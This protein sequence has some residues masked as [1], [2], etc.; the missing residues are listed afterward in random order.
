MHRPTILLL[1]LSSSLSTECGDAL[2]TCGYRVASVSTR[3]EFDRLIA[4]TAPTLAIVDDADSVAAL[5]I[6]DVIGL[7]AIVLTT[8]ESEARAV[9]ALRLGALDYFRWPGERAAFLARVKQLVPA[10]DDSAAV[11]ALVGR[12]TAIRHVQQQ[13]EKAAVTDCNVL[14]VGE[15]GTGKE[16][17]AGLSARASARGHVTPS[18]P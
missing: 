17:A 1:R 14:V 6:P 7:S 18:L 8:T 16:L 15:T 4:S 10:E 5:A 9:R 3:Q 13:I 11:R 12:S 2:Q